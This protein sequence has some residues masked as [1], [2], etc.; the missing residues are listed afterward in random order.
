MSSLLTL[1]ADHRAIGDSLVCLSVQRDTDRKAGRAIVPNDLNAADCLA[2]GP[3]SNGFHALFSESS[4]AH[5][6]SFKSRHLSIFCKKRVARGPI[7]ALSAMLQS[8]A[9]TGLTASHQLGH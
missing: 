9:Y 2:A 8:G 5:W 6:E 4:V 1:D 3:L 7:V